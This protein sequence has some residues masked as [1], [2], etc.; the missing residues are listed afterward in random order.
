MIYNI[1]ST[2]ITITAK[3]N[4]KATTNTNTRCHSNEQLD[5]NH[6]PKHPS[7][8]DKLKTKNLFKKKHVF[9]FGTLQSRAFWK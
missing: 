1:N 2:T 3:G 9:E 4:G 6:S 7:K 5:N 8:Q